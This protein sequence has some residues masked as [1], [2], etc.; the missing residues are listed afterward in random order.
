MPAAASAA[1]GWTDPMIA[2]PTTGPAAIPRK[3]RAPTTPSAR[4]RAAPPNRCAAAAVPTGTRTP[5]PSAWTTPRG[6]ELVHGLRRAGQRRSDRED[7]QRPHEQPPRP[8][9]VGEPAGHRHRQDV[10]QQVAV[11]D[12]ARLAQL[13]PGGAA[14]RVGQVGQD[15]RQ[16]DR[17]DHQL[18]AG[19]EDAGP[20]DGEHHEGRSAVHGGEC[21]RAL[22]MRPMSVVRVSPSRRGRDRRASDRPRPRVAPEDLPIGGADGPLDDDRHPVASVLGAAVLATR[23][24]GRRDV[25]VMGRLPVADGGL[26]ELDGPTERR[27]AVQVDPCGARRA[28][29][30]DHDRLGRVIAEGHR[31]AERVA[32]GDRRIEPERVLREIAAVARAGRDRQP[33][34]RRRVEQRR[35]HGADAAGQGAVDVEVVT[36]DDR[37]AA[38]AGPSRDLAERRPEVERRRRA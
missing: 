20:D 6:D 1:S 22:R 11:D 33:G 18:E 36:D 7:D 34:A 28:H 5:P 31:L 10:D 26:A 35:R 3:V 21:R 2:A 14:V 24:R 29:G 4:G 16:G 38:V 17:G 13:D 37:P 27:F 15:R 25:P 9:Q 32:L 19:Q 8:P 30:A 12:P 23:Q